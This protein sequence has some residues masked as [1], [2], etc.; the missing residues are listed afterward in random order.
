MWKK[1]A[2]QEVALA[3]AGEVISLLIFY[4]FN[5]QGHLASGPIR[6]PMDVALDVA[7]EVALATLR[8]T[9]RAAAGGGFFSQFSQFS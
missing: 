7:L 6:P 1:A 5:T 2:A 3:R 8:A 4:I 9:S